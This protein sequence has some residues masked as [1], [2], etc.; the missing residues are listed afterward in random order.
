MDGGF[1]AREVSFVIGAP[2]VEGLHK[3][4]IGASKLSVDS[5]ISRQF[6]QQV[7]IVGGRPQQRGAIPRS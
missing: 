1:Q 7:E 3:V 6:A 4:V 2:N 5:Y